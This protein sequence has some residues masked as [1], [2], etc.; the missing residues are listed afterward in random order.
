[1]KIVLVRGVIAFDK[2]SD[3]DKDEISLSIVIAV[4]VI[5]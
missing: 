2:V 5:D 4:S 1:M 3:V